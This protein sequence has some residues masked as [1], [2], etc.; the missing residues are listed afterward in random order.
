[1]KVA[2]E[3]RVDEGLKNGENVHEIKT[4]FNIQIYS[5]PLT[6]TYKLMDNDGIMSKS[7][8]KKY[9]KYINYY[10]SNCIHTKTS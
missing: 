5:I 7:F 9:R 3:E 1:M 8:Q 10:I 6:S 2:L 4:Q